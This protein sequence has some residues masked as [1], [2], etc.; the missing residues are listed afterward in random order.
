[1]KTKFKIAALIITFSSLMLSSCT[2]DYEP[3]NIEKIS[4]DSDDY[5]SGIV[6]INNDQYIAKINDHNSFVLYIYS[7]SCSLCG[8]FSPM[9]EKSSNELGIR[10]YKETYVESTKNSDLHVIV[11]YAPYLL[12]FKDGVYYTGLD[13]T[14]DKDTEYFSNQ[15][16]L[17]WWFNQLINFN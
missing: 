7:P 15:P 8:Q 1:M 6:E 14:A 3:L 9:I 2:N 17:N 10:I 4:I 13:S 11:K 12:L 16:K 5:V